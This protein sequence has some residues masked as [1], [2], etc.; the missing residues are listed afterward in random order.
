MTIYIALLRGIN[1]GGSNRIKMSELRQAL[2]TIG[3]DRVQTY[4]QSGNILFESEKGVETLQNQIKHEIEKTFGFS[5]EVVMRTAEEL[6]RIIENCPFSEEAI[7]EAESL[8]EGESL[9]V[10]ML[11]DP[12]LEEGLNK[13]SAYKTENEEYRIEGKEVY[14]LFRQSIRNSKLA[15]NLKKIGVPSTVR[16]WKTINKLSTM[17]KGM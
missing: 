6:E 7:S 4:I 16:N 12:P 9:Y 17:A 14:L 1:V 2:E 15:N 13:L 5:V 10:S 3:L 8:S 11:Q